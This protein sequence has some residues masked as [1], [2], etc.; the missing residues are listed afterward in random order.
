MRVIVTFINGN[1]M[2]GTLHEGHSLADIMNDEDLFIP[3]TRPN[4]TE[5]QLNKASVAYIVE[6][7]NHGTH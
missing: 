1:T 6:E 2:H 4:G 7:Q 5:V 3:F